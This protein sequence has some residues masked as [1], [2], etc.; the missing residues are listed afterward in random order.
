MESIDTWAVVLAT[1]LGPIFAVLTTRY[2]DDRKS[3][4]DRQREI[5]ET[6]M[7]TR[8]SFL[9]QEHVNSL[10]RIE[11]H[12]S[13]DVEV[14]SALR[15]YLD[16][17]GEATPQEQE[18]Q[19]VFLARRRR[20]FVDLIHLIGSR[21]RF[22]TDRLDLVEGGYYPQGWLADEETQRANMKLL[23]ELLSGSRPLWTSSQPLPPTSPSPFP[24]A[25]E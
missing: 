19:E 5:F 24:P 9:S 8:R 11:L 7:L 6:L 13:T 18:R 15:A 14:M 4:R 17:L 16:H 2:L 10:N 25:P 20:L 21:L 3:R 12:F 1:F 22:P 23:R